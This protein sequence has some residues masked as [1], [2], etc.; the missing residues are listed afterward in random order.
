MMAIITIN[1]T[2]DRFYDGGVGLNHLS[3]YP[4]LWDGKHNVAIKEPADIIRHID[5][6]HK[7]E[8]DF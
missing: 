1:F 7:G 3:D 4:V 6:N 5:K 2:E 8:P